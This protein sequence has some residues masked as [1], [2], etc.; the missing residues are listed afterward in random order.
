MKDKYLKTFVEAFAKLYLDKLSALRKDGD[1][2]NGRIDGGLGHD[3]TPPSSYD[4]FFLNPS[5][6]YSHMVRDGPV[7]HINASNG[8]VL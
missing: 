4:D 5:L 7:C 6:I 8:N 2:N 3:V 1:K